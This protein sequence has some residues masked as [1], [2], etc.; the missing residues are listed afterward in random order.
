MGHSL[1]KLF[2][3]LLFVSIKGHIMCLGQKKS[4]MA[5][6]NICSGFIVPHHSYMAYFISDNVNGFQFNLGYR[7]DGSRLWHQA[8]NYPIVG[9]GLHRSG[10]GNDTLYGSLTGAYIFINRSFL[11]IGGRFN[12]SNILSVGLSFAS[13]WHN[14][15]SYRGN[16]V[17]GTP[18]NAFLQYEIEASY[19]ITGNHT[20]LL[21]L[22]LTHTSNGS[23]KAPNLGFNILSTSLGYRYLFK[24]SAPTK[25]NELPDDTP[26]N[27]W[28][29]GLFG[30][31][32]SVDAFSRKQY[33]VTGLTTEKLYR[34]APLSMLGFEI[35]AYY[36]ASITD[37]FIDK[38][39]TDV[40]LHKVDNIAVAANATYLMGLGRLYIAFQP[41]IYLKNKFYGLGALTNKLGLRYN[42]GGNLFLNLGIKVHW[43][44]Q[45]DFIEF[46][47]KYSLINK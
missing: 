4:V 30:S 25:N 13:K 40:V 43:R 34:I 23:V 15:S 39:E 11:D 5:E 29:F 14:L 7:T 22:G 1:F 35:S 8:Y 18:V 20:L 17:L 32:K 19:Q 42:I 45:A 2:L 47:V 27:N 16:M 21:G 26:L 38:S 10:L 12:I 46:G 24:S 37:L 44:A 28:N 9:I 36:D 33:G 41:G 31:I 3:V 6:L